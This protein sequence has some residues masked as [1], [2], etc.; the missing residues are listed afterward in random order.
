MVSRILVIMS[1]ATLVLAV[2]RAA[3]AKSYVRFRGDAEI[4]KA[5]TKGNGSDWERNTGVFRPFVEEAARRNL[6]LKK[7]SEI[8]RPFRSVVQPPI[9]RSRS[10][11]PQTKFFYH[12]DAVIC[13]AATTDD[14]TAWGAR[15][16]VAFPYVQEAVARGLSLSVC[17]EQGR[18]FSQAAARPKKAAANQATSLSSLAEFQA[19][20]DAYELGD[21]AKALKFWRPLARQGNAKAQH[22]LGLMLELGEG[23]VKDAEQ[24]GQW[25]RKSAELGYAEA[26]NHLGVNYL[27]GSGVEKNHSEA[28]KWLHKAAKQD[29]AK[30][31]HNMGHI[32]LLGLGVSIDY[33]EAEKWFQKAAKQ[34]L[35]LSQVALSHMYFLGQGVA[36][37]PKEGL[38]WLR[39]AAGQDDAV[40]QV[41]LGFMYETGEWVAKDINKAD[42]LYEKVAQQS[43]PQADYILG[44]LYEGTPGIAQNLERATKWYRKAAEQGNVDAKA[45]L[46]VFARARSLLLSAQTALK[47]LGLY[48]G[49]LDGISGPKTQ[50]ALAKWHDENGR[51]G[52][53]ELTT[54]FVSQMQRQAE[55]K[56]FQNRIAANTKQKARTEDIGQQAVREHQLDMLRKRHKH[57]IAV[58]IGNRSYSNN[59][60]SVDFAH[61]DA[62]AIREYVTTVLRYREGNIIDLRD[63]SLGDLRRVFGDDKSHKGQLFNYV[64][65]EKSDVFV[66]YSGHG[67]PGLR[68]Q[69]GYLLPKDGDANLA[70]LT[71][72]PLDTLYANLHKLP[73]KS[74]TV[75]IDACFSGN[76][77]RGML[78]RATSGIVVSAKTDN[79]NGITLLTA[80][81]GD[82]V[83]S[84]DEDAE[85]GL[86]TKYFLLGVRGA[87]DGDE[88]GNG[89]GKVTLAEMR[90]YLNDEMTYQARRR[91]GREQN[92][93]LQGNR[94]TVLATLQ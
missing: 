12:S 91:Y 58:I 22:R 21:Y 75:V 40:A 78:V 37:D 63:A 83:A 25:F 50:S 87:A 52:G 92:P 57:A 9:P 46:T 84:W 65:P 76:T 36:K 56:G 48:E 73:A 64:R 82:Q 59:L 23:L 77:S 69:R 8:L 70:E 20:K 81:R 55:A 43:D 6:T 94:Q 44:S 1:I 72:Y 38:K 3:N 13:N 11:N 7:C 39:R 14:G 53:S 15:G 41:F 47:K 10:S 28:A 27:D 93:T 61:N 42:K 5:A 89:D 4:C 34:G 88:F 51:I 67:V 62:K 33:Q 26:Q 74:V 66:F 18:P 2:E 68:D 16:S 24:A 79:A 54:E 31:Q 60:P 80:A 85:Q 49:E 45:R 90:N 17:A 30:A 29:H 19:G 32:Y 86:F 71:G 35:A